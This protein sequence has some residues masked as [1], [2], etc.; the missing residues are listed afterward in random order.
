MVPCGS[1]LHEQGS[2]DWWV[3][4]GFRLLAKKLIRKRGC[5]PRA[6]SKHT[7]SLWNQTA[8]ISIELHD[9]AESVCRWRLSS[10]KWS[11]ATISLYT[12]GVGWW[13][14]T[15]PSNHMETQ[16]QTTTTKEWKHLWS[17]K[18]WKHPTRKPWTWAIGKTDSVDTSSVFC[19]TGVECPCMFVRRG[20]RT[21]PEEGPFWANYPPPVRVHIHY[22]NDYT[23]MHV[24]SRAGYMD[25]FML[26]SNH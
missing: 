13:T 15:M 8:I 26:T 1:E 7:Q 19:A 10:R 12:Q 20:Q 16:A 5:Q 25:T 9:L 21:L 11:D 24:V 22:D 2:A 3:V 17:H 18:S 6:T 14:G 4:L 23:T